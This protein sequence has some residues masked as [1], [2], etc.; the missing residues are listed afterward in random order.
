MAENTTETK[1]GH[2]QLA[3]NTEALAGTDTGKA[4]TPK[5]LEDKIIDYGKVIAKIASSTLETNDRNK[6]IIVNLSTATTITV[7][8]YWMK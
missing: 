2:I 4:I 1:K 3:T 6:V 8:T 5:T 7:P